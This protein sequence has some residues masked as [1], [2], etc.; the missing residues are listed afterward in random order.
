[1]QRIRG[2][3]DDVSRCRYLHECSAEGRD[4]RTA[5]R[6]TILKTPR[7][8]T[9]VQYVASDTTP[10][11]TPRRS[12]LLLYLH[13]P[14]AHPSSDIAGARCKRLRKLVALLLPSAWLMWFYHRRTSVC[15]QAPPLEEAYC[16][17]PN[18]IFV[19]LAPLGPPGTCRKPVVTNAAL[20]FGLG[21]RSFDG[22]ALGEVS[23]TTFMCI[24]LDGGETFRRF[25][26]R[27]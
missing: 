16:D 12:I 18:V 14:T 11:P 27:S 13:L 15:L 9:H 17:D 2:R 4:V 6:G 23:L 1:M 3:R 10:H 24:I 19:G 26:N 25:F 7:G 5:G 8:D 21:W 20:D 22:A